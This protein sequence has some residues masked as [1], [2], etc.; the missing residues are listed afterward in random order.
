M[1]TVPFNALSRGWLANSEEVQEACARVIKNGHYIHGPEHAAFEVELAEF[2]G[3]EEAIGVASG[4]DALYLAL[5]AVGCGRDSKIIT[6][7][8]AGG[9][10]SIVAAGIGC[11]IIYCDVDPESL[12]ITDVTL[13]P[14]LSKDIHAVVITHLYGNTAPVDRILKICEPLGI[15]VIEDCAQ[16]IGGRVGTQRVGTVGHIG[17]FSFYP[18]KNLGAAGDGGAVV[19]N[20]LALAAQVRK[21]RQYGWDGRY[22][23]EISGGIN[24][25]LDEI[26][27]AILRI[28]LPKVDLLNTKRREIVTRYRQAF[29]NTQLRIVTEDSKYST[30]HLAVVRV[31]KE[32]G[33]D[34]FQSELSA[35]GI[36]TAVHYPILD[37]DQAGLPNRGTVDQIPVSRAAKDEIVSLPCFPE[38]TSTEVTTVVTAV[39]EI[40]G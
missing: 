23:I 30:S 25:R 18:T 13:A 26:Q 16:A 19:T 15:K 2:L 35:K 3:A 17:A 14:L 20:D 34:R 36:Q 11:E 9:Y 37:C 22:S 10:T 24:S 31:P 7:A 1:V 8:N 27:A 39:L 21:L 29:L 5:K 28:G 4:T 12:V 38:L 33:R 40:V 32:I 6:A